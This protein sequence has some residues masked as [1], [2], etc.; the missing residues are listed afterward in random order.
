MLGWQLHRW[1]CNSI[2]VYI[3][4]IEIFTLLTQ[5][6]TASMGV[7]QS[8]HQFQIEFIRAAFMVTWLHKLTIKNS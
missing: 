3:S 1:F 4:Q 5:V 6:R 7:M 8:T 2:L